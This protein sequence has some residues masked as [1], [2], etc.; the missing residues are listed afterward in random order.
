VKLSDIAEARGYA[1][2]YASD[3]RRGKGTT[4]VST[5]LSTTPSTWGDTKLA[6]N[7]RQSD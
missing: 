4:H 7:S 2:A 6:P 3:V 5:N 1:K